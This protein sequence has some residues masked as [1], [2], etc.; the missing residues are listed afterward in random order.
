MSGNGIFEAHNCTIALPSGVNCIPAGTGGGCVETGPFKRYD[1]LASSY[2]SSIVCMRT[3]LTCFHSMTV[4]LGPINQV[5][6]IPELHPANSTFAYNPRCLRRDVSVWVSSNWK[7]EAKSVDLIENSGD[8]LTF[9]NRMQG[10][11]TLGDYGVHGGGHFTIG[12]DPGGVSSTV[13]HTSP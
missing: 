9:Q 7:T 4:N 5:L 2:S 8:I 13:L 1:F 3:P 12:G 11:S 10:N 6:Q